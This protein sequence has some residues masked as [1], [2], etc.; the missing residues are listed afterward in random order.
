MSPVTMNMNVSLLRGI[1]ER[2]KNPL[3]SSEIDEARNLVQRC[4]E[5]RPVGDS[6]KAAINRASKRL[7][8]SN[9]RTTDIWYGNARRIDAREMDQL[10]NCASIIEI[11]QAIS[12][13]TMFRSRL[14]GISTPAARQAIDGID[15]V[16]RIL[17]GG[18]HIGIISTSATDVG[19]L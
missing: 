1:T 2:S 18:D 4:A 5:P 17:G 9:T 16:L 8:F 6:V 15:A 3:D 11:K 12:D 10:R 13:L 19:A 14:S 7:G